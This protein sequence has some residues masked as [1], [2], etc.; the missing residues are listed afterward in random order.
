VGVRKRD[1]RKG[2]G[3]ERWDN[4]ETSGGSNEEFQ[5]AREKLKKMKK[6]LKGAAM[7]QN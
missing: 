1:S 3:G 2:M 7:A 5:G 4:R 6:T